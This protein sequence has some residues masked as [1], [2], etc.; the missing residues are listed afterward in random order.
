MIEEIIHRDF[1]VSCD[2]PGLGTTC[3]TLSLSTPTEAKLLVVMQAQG[4]RLPDIDGDGKIDRGK[5]CYCGPCDRVL[6]A[7][8]K[9]QPKGQ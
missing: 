4:W 1:Q 7:A 5:P 6:Q 9:L 3:P 8:G 2:G